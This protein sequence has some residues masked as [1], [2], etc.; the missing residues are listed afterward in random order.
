[1]SG[2]TFSALWLFHLLATKAK[3]SA[4]RFYN[5]LVCQ[6]NAIDPAVVP[7]RYGKFLRTTRQWQFLQDLKH[8]GIEDPTAPPANPGDLALKC[9]ACPHPKENLTA[10][11]VTAAESYVSLRT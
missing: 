3:L 2:F 7:N 8:T 10:A 6:T 5:V 9:P 1:M 11:D 4:Q